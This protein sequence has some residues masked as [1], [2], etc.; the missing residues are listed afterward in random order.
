M[1]RVTTLYRT[2]SQ[3]IEVVLQPIAASDRILCRALGH[4]SRGKLLPLHIGAMFGSSYYTLKLLLEE[5][6][7]GAKARCVC[8][9]D[10]EES[11]DVTSLLPVYDG[12]YNGEEEE[13]GML[14]IELIECTRRLCDDI[15]ETN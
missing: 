2:M 10:A 12:H 15:Q 14:P 6:P 8:F 5:Y 7:E 13:E 1:A 3:C 11:G 9:S 4:A